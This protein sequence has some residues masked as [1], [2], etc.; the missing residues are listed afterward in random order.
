MGK[1]TCAFVDGIHALQHREGIC[2]SAWAPFRFMKEMPDFQWHRFISSGTPRVLI[3]F[4]LLQ[5]ENHVFAL[6]C[7][8][9]FR[10]QW[11]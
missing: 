9:V 3:G 4:V 1:G 6:G 10:E 11:V 8:F 5:S 2:A 7:V